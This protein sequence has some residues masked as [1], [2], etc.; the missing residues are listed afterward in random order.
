LAFFRRSYH[1]HQPKSSDALSRRTTRRDDATTEHRAKVPAEKTTTTNI[2]AKALAEKTITTNIK[3]KAL[4]KNS[5]NRR[6]AKG[7]GKTDPHLEAK[8]LA[9]QTTTLLK[10]KALA[11]KTTHHPSQGTGKKD[12]QH[13]NRRRLRLTTTQSEP[14]RKM[15]VSQRPS[16][17]LLP[18]RTHSLTPSTDGQRVHD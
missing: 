14:R 6:E 5:L 12:H 4:A 11:K 2:K 3:A 10:A 9:K 18:S 16:P 17:P 8:A 13:P 7:Q 1:R 15:I